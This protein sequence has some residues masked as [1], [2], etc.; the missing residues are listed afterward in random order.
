MNE[1]IYGKGSS[2]AHQIL[3]YVPSLCSM[4]DQD[5]LFL[6]CETQVLSV[7]SLNTCE[8]GVP[9]FPVYLLKNWGSERE[10]DTAKM[11]YGLKRLHQEKEFS[12]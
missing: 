6:A 11:I 9:S 3:G 5:Y 12:I 8:I 2:H 1:I 7:I 10:S 4:L